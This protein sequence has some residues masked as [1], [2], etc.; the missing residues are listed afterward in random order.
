MSNLTLDRKIKFFI[1]ER[2]E[3]EI[4]DND[5]YK[6][7]IHDLKSIKIIED[8]NDSLGKDSDISKKVND[9]RDLHTCELVNMMELAYRLG[10]KD[11]LEFEDAM[12]NI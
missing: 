9:I 3:E 1:N 7:N 12:F 4:Y 11:G 10:F 5:K 6:D 8:I 2:I